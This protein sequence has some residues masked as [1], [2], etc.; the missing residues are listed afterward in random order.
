MTTAMDISKW[1]IFSAI[2]PKFIATFKLVCVFGTSG[3]EA[4]IITKDDQVYALGNNSDGCLGLPD[5]SGVLELTKIN[6]LCNKNIKHFAYGTGPHVLALTN[7]GEVYSW[8]YNAYYQTGIETTSSNISPILISANLLPKK[9]IEIACGSNHSLALTQDGEVF[10]WG[11][12]NYGQC[13]HNTTQTQKTPRKISS[14]IAEKRVISVVCGENNSICI[15]DNGEVYSWGNNYSGQLGTGSNQTQT[16]PTNVVNLT[17]IVIVKVVCGYAHTLALSDEGMLYGWGDNSYG[18]LGNG[19]RDNRAIP[20]RVAANI[21]RVVD[22]AA[23]HY[24]YLSAALTQL[25]QVYVWGQ[26]R[27]QTVPF[28]KETLFHS[29]HEVFY[30]YSNPPFTY[31][32]IVL[33][34]LHTP[35]ITIN[36]SLKL[37]FD[38][39]NTSD[40]KFVIEGKFVHVHK[41]ILK[42]RCDHFRSM[43][44]D[45]W[46][47]DSKEVVEIKQFTYV[48]Y[49]A[50]LQYLYTNEVDLSPHDAFD[51][52]DLANCYCECQ[53]KRQCQQM[54]KRQTTVANAALFYVASIKH[55]D[56]DLEEFCFRFAINH[57]T[58][59]VQTEAFAHLDESTV[60]CFILKAAVEGAF[61]Y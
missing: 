32:P 37:A 26:C 9:V 11:S 30:S 47:E 27:G 58:E 60:K 10:S 39:S 49:R 52:L 19:R 23:F 12:N 2:N 18:Q 4:L 50:F 51:L 13:G 1:A 31:A 20:Q 3:N 24:N 29:L 33:D 42:I 45:H 8:G 15:I 34:D 21:E 56:K 46:A 59:V 54:I 43:F 35:T 22:I 61:K 25:C 16:I 38:D 40:M 48:V 17:G 55:E 41:A 5:C 6:E 53:L 36:D 14:I 7:A 28:P 44:Q 57:L